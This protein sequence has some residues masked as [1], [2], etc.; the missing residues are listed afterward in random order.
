[1]EG[2]RGIVLRVQEMS[3]D[4][5]VSHGERGSKSDS[6]GSEQESKNARQNGRRGRREG[7]SF[8]VAITGVVAA[9]R[10][11]ASRFRVG[12]SE[13]IGNTVV[14]CTNDLS[15]GLSQRIDRPLHLQ[16][17]RCQYLPYARVKAKR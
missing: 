17:T 4:R 15:A 13:G 12:G 14:I 6:E 3:Q 5:D 1:M 2:I 9:R 16:K 10:I 8:M 11:V 7:T